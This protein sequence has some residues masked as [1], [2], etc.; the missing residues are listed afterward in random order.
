[1]PF[2]NIVTDFSAKKTVYGEGLPERSSFAPFSGDEIFDVVIVGGGLTGLTAATELAAKNKKVLLLEAK[3]IGDGPSGRNG[4]QVIPGFDW[5]MGELIK[6]FGSDLSV[7]LWND[8]EAARGRLHQR[9]DSEPDKCD[10]Q[11]GVIMAAM[12]GEHLSDAKEEEHVLRTEFNFNAVRTLDREEIKQ[13]INSPDYV[14]GMIYEDARHINPE[15]YVRHLT[16][17]AQDAGVRIAENSPVEKFSKDTSGGFYLETPEGRVMTPNV[18]IA[19]GAKFH[20]PEGLDFDTLG[21]RFVPTQTVIVATEPM[22]DAAVE[23]AIPGTASWFDMRNSMNYVRRT[24]DNRILFGGCDA[25][26]DLMTSVSAQALMNDMYK[27]LPSLAE[28]GV[29]ID[30]CWSGYVDVSK[31]MLPGIRRL[32]AGLYEASGF[33]GHGIVLTGLAGEAIAEDI[34]TGGKSAQLERL[35][36]IAPGEFNKNPVL[37]KSQLLREWLAPLLHDKLTCRHEAGLALDMP[38]WPS[39]ASEGPHTIS[40]DTMMNAKVFM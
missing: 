28:D 7:Q 10:T 39:A 6:E 23:R 31:T 24:P 38:R 21:R 11:T 5:G 16:K 14:G 26:S 37:A 13:H 1:M 22:S 4:G 35:T 3:T 2:N 9:I 18:V 33:S 25:F 19:C 20:R 15:K 30:T 8:V 27:V 12:N 32:E 17:M 29:K 40:G 34:A 36:K